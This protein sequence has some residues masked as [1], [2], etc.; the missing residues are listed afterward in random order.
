MRKLK[1]CV[2]CSVDGFIARE[3]HAYDFLPGE[4]D[5]ISDFIES[6]REFDIALMGRNTYEVGLK[7]G[8]IDPSLPLKQYVV[9]SSLPKTID[10]R[11]KIV[12]TD[13]KNFVLELKSEKG[14]NLLL[15]GGSILATTLLSENLIDEIQLRVHPVIIGSGIPIFHKHKDFSLQIIRQKKY[16][17]AVVLNV[18]GIG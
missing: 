2:D 3:N 15:S 9:S 11:I 1:Y 18:Y 4:G 8:I 5:H 12:S 10:G 14:K 13:I 7:A 17:N 16:S 6:I